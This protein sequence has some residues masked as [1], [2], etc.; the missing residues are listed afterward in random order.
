ML[1]EVFLFGLA[2]VALV[3]A[4]IAVLWGL[5]GMYLGR[6]YDKIAATIGEDGVLTG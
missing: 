5:T 4:V 2:G 3:A 1:R 6:R